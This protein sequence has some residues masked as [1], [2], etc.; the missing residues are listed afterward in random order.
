MQQ[1][2][3]TLKNDNIE[4]EIPAAGQ[5]FE[6]G[7]INISLAQQVLHCEHHELI[8]TFRKLLPDHQP[9]L[10]AGC[11]SGCW[12]IWFAN[13]GW[14]TI[15]LDWSSTLINRARFEYPK[16][17]F[18]IGDLRIMPFQDEEFGSIVSLGAIEHSSEGPIRA[19]KEFHRILKPGG[20][21]IITVPYLGPIRRITRGLFNEPIRILKRN[22]YLRSLF[23][24][25]TGERTI[26]EVNRR[27][28]PQYAVDY[29]ITKDG[30]DFFQ[31]YFTEKQIHSLLEEANFTILEGFPE[32][33]DDGILH[34]FGSITGKF[35]F[36]QGKVSFS[37]FGKILR[38]IIPVEIIG[39]MYCCIVIKTNEKNN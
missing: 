21:A 30:W 31:Y 26:E 5:E 24:K 27:L 13:N 22:R 12:V 1:K 34:T 4:I 33:L 18:E 7:F 17:R 16:L 6:K 25:Y 14:Q 39:H 11:G 19:I 37:W 10:E 36:Q 3:E 28:I 9:I 15:G 29:T 8:N 35:D 20:I 32:F 2:N 23:N 38:K